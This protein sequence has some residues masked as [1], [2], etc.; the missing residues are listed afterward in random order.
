MSATSCTWRARGRSAFVHASTCAGSLHRRVHHACPLAC[1]RAHARMHGT[2]GTHI[3]S[4]VHLCTSACM[5]RHVTPRHAGSLAARGPREFRLHQ[6]FG[7][8]NRRGACQLCR[9][10]YTHASTHAGI[11]L[12]PAPAPPSPPPPPPPP[13]LPPPPPPLPPPL[14]PI[15]PSAA[16]PPRRITAAIQCTSRPPPHPP[17]HP[18]VVHQAVQHCLGEAGSGEPVPTGRC[19]LRS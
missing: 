6:A 5:P 18:P 4:P 14:M 12:P 7:L 10:R 1:V 2:H 11:L 8:H 13:P 16:F 19:I 17:T 9:V 3:Q 15:H